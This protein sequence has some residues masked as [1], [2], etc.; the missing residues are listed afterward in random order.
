M[1]N[2]SK[3]TGGAYIELNTLLK[4]FWR[5]FRRLFW[6]VLALAAAGGAVS[7]FTAWRAYTPM[8]RASATFTVHV[9]GRYGS[10][11]SYYNSA[12]A[13]QMA[14]TFPSILNSGILSDIVAADLGME[15]LPAAVSANAGNANLFTITS[16]SRSAQSAYDVLESV[17]KNYPQIAEFV[18]GDTELVL[19]DSSGLPSAPYNE[20]AYGARVKSGALI[21]ALLGLAVIIIL[22]ASRRT[23]RSEEDIKR[24]LNIR[25]L[26]SL[27][28]V[29]SKKRRKGS[30]PAVLAYKETTPRSY[31]DSV[32][33][34]ANRLETGLKERDARVL[35]VSSAVP[36]EGKTTV[37]CSLARAFVRQGLKVAL[38]NCD[39]R[40]PSVLAC[41]GRS[42]KTKGISDLI[43]GHT[44]PDEIFIAIEPGLDVV[45][46]GCPVENA[47][48]A[49][50]SAP[51]RALV[52][53]ALSCHDL[54]LLDT[55]PS[56]MLT[57]AVVA[58]RYADAA[59]FVVR[60]NY[61]VKSAVS[62][63][64][65]RL[66]DTGIH[67]AGCVLNGKEA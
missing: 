2:G 44:A 20:P 50:D 22:A 17:I 39:L 13:E 14:K 48:E 16:E 52:E 64:V 66:A 29:N 8:Y 1:E 28:Y 40:N 34:L 5:Y 33:L 9:T 51:I 55:P 42:E 25:C 57:D 49:L 30:A 11:A 31:T 27:P 59:L 23:V 56:H 12:T 67:F 58:A 54:V 15:A 47:S 3:E 41:F 4:D 26:A 63:G 10:S 38:I 45:P 37:A 18:V 65:Q 19:I 43:S 32:R 7:A 36:G 46:V 60:Q 6:L 24:M 35:L 21:G 53:H 62:D 61:A